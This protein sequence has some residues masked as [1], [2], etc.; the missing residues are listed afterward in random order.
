MDVFLLDL[1]QVRS[2]LYC[3]F[4][5]CIG[6]RQNLGPIQPSQ[7]KYDVPRTFDVQYENIYLEQYSTVNIKTTPLIRPLLGSTT[8]GLNRGILLYF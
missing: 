1:L 5:G 6:P 7:D 8:G 2:Q 4:D 3:P